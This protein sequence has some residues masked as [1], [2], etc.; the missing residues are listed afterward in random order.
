MS[1]PRLPTC[2]PHDLYFTLGPDAKAGFPLP[3]G[4]L[5]IAI[6]DPSGIPRIHGID[7]LTWQT[8]LDLV[9]HTR[10]SNPNPT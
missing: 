5:P 9:A 1:T 2:T 7:P 8:F 10:S 4:T 6:P 3:D